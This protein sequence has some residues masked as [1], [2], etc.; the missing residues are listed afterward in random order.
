MST[1]NTTNIKHASSSTNSIVLAADGRLRLPADT[2]DIATLSATGTA[3]SSTFLRGDNA[4]S[5]AGKILQVVHA[6]TG[7]RSAINS[8]S[9]TDCTNL[10]ASITPASAS[11]KILAIAE[12][13]GIS[14]ESADLSACSV[15]LL[16]GST[17]VAINTNM[18][19]SQS[20]PL[21][22]AVTFVSL[23][24]AAD[25]NAHVYKVQIKNRQ[26]GEVVLNNTDGGCTSS[27]TLLEVAA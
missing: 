12:C 15:R 14:S 13:V 17:E 8:T 16:Q 23:D 10:T 26:S 1:L 9:F 11:N 22:Q 24:N 27:I 6:S 25:T 3:S 19:Y 21:N 4:W 2:V 18:G 7:T 20:D 5:G